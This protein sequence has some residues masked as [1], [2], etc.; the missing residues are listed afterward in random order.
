LKIRITIQITRHA[1]CETL[2][3]VDLLTD[4]KKIKEAPSSRAGSEEHQEAF[5]LY[6]FLYP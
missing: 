5:V 1:D 2:D 3:A 4:N 6:F